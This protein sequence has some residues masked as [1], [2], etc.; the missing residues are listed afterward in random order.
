MGSRESAVLLLASTLLISSLSCLDNEAPSD[1]VRVKGTVLQPD[2]GVGCSSWGIRSEDGT[3]Y[4]ITNL[5]NAFR[6]PGLAVTAHLE[7][8]R[9]MRSTC[10]G[11]IAEVIEIEMAPNTGCSGRS[12]AR[13][14]AEPER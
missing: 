1:T 11:Q 12:A 9:D 2:A 10:G 6:S 5:P 14:A 13:P 8:R 4:V 7:R 3:L